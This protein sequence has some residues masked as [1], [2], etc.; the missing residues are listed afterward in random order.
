MIYN[1]K[2]FDGVNLID[3]CID[4]KYCEDFYEEIYEDE[5]EEVYIDE[6]YWYECTRSFLGELEENIIHE[7]CDLSIRLIPVYKMEDLNV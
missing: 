7:K 1:K 4:C 3:R 5:D 6:Y 2:R